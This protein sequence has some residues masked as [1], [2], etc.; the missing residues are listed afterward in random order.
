MT[1]RNNLL[2]GLAV[3]LS[4]VLGSAH[5]LAEIASELEPDYAQAVLAYKDQNYSKA[6]KI[7]DGL[8]IKAPD[9]PE[10][11]G[12]KALTLTGQHEDQSAVKIY[13]RLIEMSKDPATIAPF[14][15][16]LGAIHYKNKRLENAKPHLQ[17]ASNAGFSRGTSEFLLG[18]ISFSEQ[19]WDEASRHFH[20]SVQAPSPELRPSAYFYL[21]QCFTRTGDILHAIEA[22]SK[23]SD[24]AKALL[25][26]GGEA[27]AKANQEIIDASAKAL[28]PMDQGSYFAD[29]SLWGGYDTNS[30]LTPSSTP[31]S[32]ASGVESAQSVVKA[33]V[34]YAASPL[35]KVQLIPSYR[36]SFNY[37]F[38]TAAAAGEFYT[39]TGTLYVN[40]NPL[41]AFKYGAKIEGNYY[42]QGSSTSVGLSSFLFLASVG[43]YV[44]FDL[45]PQWELGAELNYQPQ[46]FF[47]DPTSGDQMRSGH[48]VVTR[49]SLTN[50]GGQRLWNPRLQLTYDF[51]GTQGVEFRAHAVALEF[52]NRMRLGSRM[53]LWTALS[54]GDTVY[55]YRSGAV[56]NDIIPSAAITWSLKLSQKMSLLAQGQFT[57]NGSNVA[58]TYRWTRLLTLVGFGYTL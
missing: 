32:L 41:G 36:T 39:H 21:G 2:L 13:E 1:V 49:V 28:E 52:S 24:S 35:G 14:H 58:S 22:F 4:T 50:D 51:T 16:E 56:R 31:L 53:G 38:N 18:M 30:L 27:N 23:A 29:L 40:R 44:R 10:I 11:L 57:Y 42:L 5:A 33:G 54:I 15:F 47:Q 45:K 46:I 37:N 8:L 34:G 43:P 7:L 12:L 6:S 19:K 26:K 17:A 55:P 48:E 9:Q 20:Y 25:A 3:T